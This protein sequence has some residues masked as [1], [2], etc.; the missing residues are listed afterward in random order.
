MSETVLSV[1]GQCAVQIAALHFSALCRGIGFKLADGT[2]PGD[3]LVAEDIIER[4][5]LQVVS[6][7]PGSIANYGPLRVVFDSF[8]KDVRISI[9]VGNFYPDTRA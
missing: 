9:D 4:L 5:C 6:K 3:L 2:N 7:G 1:E 8:E